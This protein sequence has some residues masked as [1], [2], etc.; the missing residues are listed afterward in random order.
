MAKQTIRKNTPV[1]LDGQSLQIGM[2]FDLIQKV[3]LSDLANRITKDEVSSLVSTYYTIQDQRIRTGNQLSR[4]Q[5]QDK[6]AE[7]IEQ[8]FSFFESMEERIKNLMEIWV[9]RT[10]NPVANWLYS[11]CG[12]GPVLTA[13]WI[14]NIDI[15]RCRSSGAIM[16]YIGME[17]TVK[18][19]TDADKIRIV[20]NDVLDKQ[21]KKKIDYD[22][23]VE[24][25]STIG[26]SLPLT[27]NFL[28]NVK[29]YED[30]SKVKRDDLISAI[31]LCPFNQDMRK[32]A[33]KTWQSFMKVQNSS[34]DTYG[35][36]IAQRKAW[37]NE[38]NERL[39][40]KELAEEGAKRVGSSTDAFKY[41]SEG[42]LPPA[43]ILMRS[44]RFC[45]KI[46][47]SHLH[48]MLYWH[49]YNALPPRPYAMAILNHKSYIKIPN[50][51]ILNFPDELYYSTGTS[52]G[53]TYA[54]ND[55]ASTENYHVDRE[56][57]DINASEED[58]RRY[59]G[60]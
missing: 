6:P 38:K 58:L 1:M 17:P 37:E 4:F 10:D 50:V 53:E 3:D 13:G 7:A 43:H 36:L 32:L 47:V 44:G 9:T 21:S 14:A 45:I 49:H 42:K 20:I 8:M 33:W 60:H 26:H 19:H 27:E 29:K 2:I 15:T 18:W 57:D 54:V 23:I 35:K 24:V 52:N 55:Y 11:I 56:F 31:K 30:Y 41:Y 28:T 59:T 39:E 46:F 12:I 40:Y 22:V 34:K 51:D 16:R 25:C 5:A 48:A